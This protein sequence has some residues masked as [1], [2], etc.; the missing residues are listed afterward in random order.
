MAVSCRATC[1]PIAPTPITV[2]LHAPSDQPTMK[3][4]LIVEEIDL[5]RARNIATDLLTEMPLMD[6]QKILK[7][8]PTDQKLTNSAGFDT[9]ISANRKAQKP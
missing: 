1:L 7:S 3:Y 2:A 6:T 5:D 9:K 8:N 4:Y